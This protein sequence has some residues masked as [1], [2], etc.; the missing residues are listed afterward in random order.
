MMDVGKIM[1]MIV[2]HIFMILAIYGIYK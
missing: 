2:I 1:V